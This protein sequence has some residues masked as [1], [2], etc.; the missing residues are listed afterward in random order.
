MQLSELYTTLRTLPAIAEHAKAVATGFANR[1]LS[2]L[3]AVQ[4]YAGGRAPE[5]ELAELY[6]ALCTE[7]KKYAE[8]TEL[9]DRSSIEGNP[10]YDSLIIA[11]DFADVR[12]DGRLDLDE[13]VQM[14]VAS[15]LEDYTP[16][17]DEYISQLE[18]TTVL[19]EL[20]LWST[21]SRRN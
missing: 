4:D 19:D 10:K 17:I 20:G 1:N 18:N 15:L 12:S 5:D 11:L 9:N 6:N 3:M 21:S 2:P 14:T 8:T 13:F 16:S 7:V